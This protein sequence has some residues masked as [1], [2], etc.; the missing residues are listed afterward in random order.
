MEAHDDGVALY[1]AALRT[2][3]E[4][5]VAKRKLSIYRAGQRSPDWLKIK[6]TSSAEFVIGGFTKGK[7][8]RE[9]FGSL[10]V[11]YWDDA[12]KLR[13]AANVGTGYDEDNIEILLARCRSP[14]RASTRRCA[15]RG[16]GGAAARRRAPARKRRSGGSAAASRKAD[17]RTPDAETVRELLAS[18]DDCATS[19]D[20]GGMSSS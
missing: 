13:Y 12:S 17:P 1:A 2:G 11:G 15:G 9:R 10:V 14:I 20:V 4:G 7:G 19:M 5:V 3:F 18:L 6:H 16:D 8:G